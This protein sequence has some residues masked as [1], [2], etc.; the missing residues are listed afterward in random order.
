MTVA[1]AIA[2]Q[3]SGKFFRRAVFE[4]A[5][6]VVNVI[7]AEED[8]VGARNVGIENSGA[9]GRRVFEREVQ[10]HQAVVAPMPR[11]RFFPNRFGKQFFAS[12]LHGRGKIDRAR[13]E[14][15]AVDRATI[16]KLHPCGTPVGDFDLSSHLRL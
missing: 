15:A 10:R 5:R 14:F 4:T 2:H 9:V 6:D 1:R 16:S 13:H 7:H 11:F 3:Y 8:I 12:H